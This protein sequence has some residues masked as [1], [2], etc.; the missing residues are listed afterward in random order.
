MKQPKTHFLLRLPTYT[1]F[2]IIVVMSG[3]LSPQSSNN[4]TLLMNMLRMQPRASPGRLP[5]PPQNS[6]YGL[7]QMMPQMF[8]AGGFMPG[9]NQVYGSSIYGGTYGSSGAPFHMMNR[10][11]LY[12]RMMVSLKQKSTA[13]GCKSEVE[14]CC[15]PGEQTDLKFGRQF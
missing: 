12:Q 7:P 2:C 14:L 6:M 8:N 1:L 9:Q 3:A 10:P 4:G 5:F 11:G 13:G 15:S